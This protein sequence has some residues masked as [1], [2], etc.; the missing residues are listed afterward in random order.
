MTLTEKEVEKH[1]DPE[2]LL[3]RLEDGFPALEL[4]E[5]QSRVVLVTASAATKA[6]IMPL[7]S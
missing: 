3:D 6:A 5:V 4:E 7:R 1:L 2:E